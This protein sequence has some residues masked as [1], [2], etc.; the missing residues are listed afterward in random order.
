MATSLV[1][2]VLGDDRPGLVELLSSVISEHQGSWQESSMARLAGKFAGI[3]R[4]DVLD[5]AMVAPLKAELAALPHLRVTAEVAAETT[6]DTPQRRL[7]L[8]LVGQ[9]RIG[10][11]R[12]VTQV[13][14]RYGVNVEEFATHTSSAP[15]GAG[16]MFH[17]RADLRAPVTLDAR[18]LQGAL[19]RLSDELIVD[20][21]LDEV[22]P[23]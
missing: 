18:A 9:D 20:I 3:V 10:I 17:A 22:V 2:T 23:V 7:T 4:V 15:M 13:L 8:S 11:V 16:M 6:P 19:E 12:E 1:L 21:N 5:D 14:A